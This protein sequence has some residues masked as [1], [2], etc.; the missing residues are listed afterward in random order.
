MV[1]WVLQTHKTI[2]VVNHTT[3]YKDST[4]KVDNNFIKNMD[5]IWSSAKNFVSNL[6]D[7]TLVTNSINSFILKNL[8]GTNL[9]VSSLS[10][11]EIRQKIEQYT[12]LQGENYSPNSVFAYIRK[13]YRGVVKND[14]EF[15]LSTNQDT[16]FAYYQMKI[17]LIP[18]QDGTL[19]LLHFPN[20]RNKILFFAIP[21]FILYLFLLFSSYSMPTLLHFMAW[22]WFIV[23]L[24][25]NW[26]HKEDKKIGTN[27]WKT[28]L[29]ARQVSIKNFIQFS[30]Y[31]K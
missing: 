7:G 23:A 21:L 4:Y 22:A 12:E 24:S 25:R 10:P 3:I 29:Y 26:S 8:S 6:F 20:A 31:E 2:F 14:T 16:D 11:E 1:L 5:S 30:S 13:Y 28:V 9:L 15:I 19:V 18:K 27:F 17:K